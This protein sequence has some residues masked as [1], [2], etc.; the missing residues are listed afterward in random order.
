MEIK[1]E[2]AGVEDSD[3]VYQITKQA[4]QDYLGPAFSSLVPA[5]QESK[6][7]VKEDIKNKEVLIAYV[8]GMA[9]GSVRFY[10][11]NEKEYHLGRLGVLNK[12]AGKNI[13]KKLIKEVEKR[14]KASGGQEITL[15]SAYQK[16]KLLHFYQRLGYEIEE[17]REDE[18]Y[19]RVELKKQ[20]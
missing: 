20:L 2:T 5:L 9:A 1:I 7:D 18:D 11:I 15:I 12:F 8:D 17:I 13:G 10:S 19:T 16:K 6:I 3:L 14:V 4:F